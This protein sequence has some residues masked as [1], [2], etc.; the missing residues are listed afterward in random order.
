[1]KY[2]GRIA[3]IGAAGW[4]LN[5]WFNRFDRDTGY[6]GGDATNMKEEFAEYGFSER[7]M[8]AVGATKVGLAIA[9]LIG[10][11]VPGIVRP[12]GI[13]L[14]AFMAGALGMHAKVGDPLKRSAPAL[15]VLALSGTAALLADRR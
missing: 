8:Y 1:M 2:I 3:Q 7:Q 5:V 15:S 6:R 14:G 10:L 9:L 13:G 4:I 11:F 12:A